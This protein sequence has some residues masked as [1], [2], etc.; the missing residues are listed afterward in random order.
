MATASKLN[1]IVFCISLPTN[2]SQS[3]TAV[4]CFFS[5][6]IVCMP[7]CLFSSS[8]GISLTFPLFTSHLLVFLFFIFLVSY[9]NWENSV[10]AKELKKN[11]RKKVKKFQLV[12]NMLRLNW[13]VIFNSF[14]FFTFL[15]L[16]RTKLMRMCQWKSLFW[17]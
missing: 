5:F 10:T 9:A 17:H 6:P 3:Q 15:K 14:L 11:W 4:T 7:M 16:C 1:T 13:I 12:L 8:A 2:L